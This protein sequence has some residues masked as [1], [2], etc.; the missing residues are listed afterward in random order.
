[1]AATATA[2]LFWGALAWADEP[3]VAPGSRSDAM[4]AEVLFAEARASMRE[5]KF[6]EA[7]PKLEASLRLERAVGT[8]LNLAD[9]Y[10]QT[11][12][13]ASAWFWFR[14]GAAQAAKEGQ[15]ERASY[16]RERAKDL[17]PGLCRL[18]IRVAPGEVPA[19]VVV[20]RDGVVVEREAWSVPVPVDPGPHAVTTSGAEG[21]EP[22]R[23][24][25]VVEAPAE[26][27][28]APTFV[29]LPTFAAPP[30]LPALPVER[31]PPSPAPMRDVPPDSRWS[32]QH[33]LAV[34][35]G[36]AG[37]VGV[38]IGAGFG[39]RALSLKSDAD[40]GC[41]DLGCTAEARATNQAAGAS[42][43]VATVAFVSSAVLVATGAVLWF[44]AP[45]LRTRAAS[46]GLRLEF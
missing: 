8:M 1:M 39:I 3:T 5:G 21:R 14:E 34:V 23:A 12:R 10:Q 31:P 29:T 43:D 19:D 6:A 41:T 38:G 35:A 2:C 25:I 32:T 33:T 4:A 42:A 7:C 18:A 22:F 44:V 26:G 17:E 36:A 16:A 11:K 28:C 13:P 27:A 24:E 40:R 15:R 20:R 46:R 45:S 30:A 37:L 9:C